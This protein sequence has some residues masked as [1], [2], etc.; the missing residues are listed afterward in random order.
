MFVRYGPALSYSA[1]SGRAACRAMPRCRPATDLAGRQHGYL[2]TEAN[3]RRVKDFQERN[4]IV[5]IVGDFAGPKALR[6]VGG[7]LRRQGLVVRA[8]YTSNVEQ[9]LFRNGAALAFYANVATLPTDN[10]SV[11]IRSASRRSVIDPI[12]ELL[13]AVRDGR[14]LEYSGRRATRERIDP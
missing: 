8:F 3:Y 13:A 4:L 5:P 9:Y 14:I 7:Y 12:D 1:G 2:A 11:F 6:G 10:E